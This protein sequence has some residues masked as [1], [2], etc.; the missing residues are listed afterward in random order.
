MK[1]APTQR[2]L[3]RL[4]L[5][6]LGWGLVATL[7]GCSSSSKADD[8][9]TKIA[10]LQEQVRG[11]VSQINTLNEKNQRLRYENQ[12]LSQQ[13][14]TQQYATKEDEI[15]VS[16]KLARLQV[17][18]EHLA[19]EQSKLTQQ[20]VALREQLSGLERER[21]EAL[22]NLETLRETLLKEIARLQTENERLVAEQAQLAGALQQTQARTEKPLSEVSSQE[23][24]ERALALYTEMRRLSDELLQRKIESFRQSVVSLESSTCAEAQ[25]GTIDEC[26]ALKIALAVETTKRGGVQR[27]LGIYEQ[28][29][30][31]YPE[32]AMRVERLT[33]PIA[34]GDIAFEMGLL[35][36]SIARSTISDLNEQI[37][38]RLQIWQAYLE[39]H[40]T[41]L[42]ADDALWRLASLYSNGFRWSGA[43]SAHYDPT[44]AIESLKKILEL[45]QIETTERLSDLWRGVTTARALTKASVFEMLGRGYETALQNCEEALVW[46]EKTIAETTDAQK[47]TDLTAMVLYLR[48][49]CGK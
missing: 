44:K 6:L 11:L 35:R 14:N 45:P 8:D 49:S 10:K 24:E 31:D 5:V 1:N 18:N 43:N 32:L 27:A 3:A 16:R 39:K 33:R 48:E 26:L 41:S 36:E 23:L 12:S 15:V 46:Y 37:A 21:D 47:K 42:Y 28:M 40:P 29:L 19:G 17:E 7:S 34:A 2:V 13:L 9:Q 25:T 30:K 38:A 22:K 20:L 4:V